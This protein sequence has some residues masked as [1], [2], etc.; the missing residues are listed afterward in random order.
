MTQALTRQ[1][2]I[3]FFIQAAFIAFI[4][5]FIFSFRGI[6]SISIA[7]ILL[8][9]MLENWPNR[10]SCA[11]K[12]LTQPFLIL[13]VVYYVLQFVALL[14]TTDTHEGWNNIRLKS[15]LV[16][17]PLAM[18]SSYNMPASVR[19]RLINWF[20]IILTIASLY[21]L[22][23]SVLHYMEVQ[24]RYVLF[25]HELVSP[26]KQHA[27]YFSIFVF[28]ALAWLLTT[29]RKKEFIFNKVFHISLIVFLSFFLLL[30]SSKIVIVYYAI[31]LIW[32]FVSFFKRHR[33]YRTWILSFIIV[34]IVAGCMI[35]LTTNPISQRFNDIL[36]GDIRFI[37]RDKFDRAD[38]F[39][40]VQFRLLQWRLVSDVLT[41]NRSWLTGAGPGDAQHLLDQQY[42]SKNMYQGDP[43]K[44]GSKGY[45]AYNTHNQF[46]QSLLQ[47]GIIGAL[48]F[49]LITFTL[50]R[51]AW[52][53]R[54]SMYIFIVGLLIVYS[55]IESVFE[56]QYGILLYCFFALFMKAPL[57]NG[58]PTENKKA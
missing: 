36:R 6:T 38:Y 25:Y 39:N 32:Y 57:D 28:V 52:R 26:I 10:T 44:P 34:F 9:G 12:I 48:V 42:I 56:T 54:N 1:K 2:A 18:Y 43:N 22:V 4:I 30:L 41:E 46:L 58:R 55:L 7:A 13:C 51:M 27:V 53:S 3:S 33:G 8:G 45:L 31:F 17:I 23:I 21:C 40:G 24:S 47:T 49:L 37:L 29:L 11:P 16:F 15:G 20:C 19:K 14:Y 50:A 5:S 35:M